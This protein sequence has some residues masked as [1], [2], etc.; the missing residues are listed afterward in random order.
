M[1]DEHKTI[2]QQIRKLSDQI[3]QLS[4]RVALLEKTA[5]T[6]AT[7]SQQRI[8]VTQPSSEA[9]TVEDSSLLLDS[10][11]L[12][13][14]VSILCFLLVAALGLRALTDS[15]ILNP[16]I[17]SILG[18][19]YAAS[20]II[21]S[22]IFYRGSSPLAP[23]FSI[24]GALLMF[25][26]MVE[27]HNH[28]ATLPEEIA[29]TMLATTGIGMAIISYR[30]KVALPII[31][32]TLGMCFSAVAIGYPT[33]HFPYLGL[34][35]WASNI[36]GFFATRLKRCSWL[37]WLL[38]LTTHLMLQIWG[39]KLSGFMTYGQGKTEQLSPGLFI[40]V[41]TLIGFTFMMIALF[42][43]IRSGDDKVSKFD[44]SLPALNASWCYVA[45]I[46]ALKNPTAFGAPAA[47]AAFIHFA[48]AYWLS[49]RQTSNA[50]G[51]NTFTAGGVILACLSLPAVLGDLFLSLPA[52]SLLAIATCYFAHRWSSGGMRIT[53][54][55]LQAYISVIFVIEFIRSIGQQHKSP[56]IFFVVLFCS[57][58]ALLHYHYARQTKPPEHSRIFSQYDRKDLSALL[59]LFAGLINSYFTCMLIAFYC[60]QYYY[61]EE[62]TIALTGTQSIVI[63]LAAIFI[64]V[65]S[66]FN[67][68]PELRN[69]S[70]L[71]LAIGGCKV[72]II[73]MLN[74]SGAWLVCSIFTFGVAAALASLIL[75]RW[76]TTSN[77]DTR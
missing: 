65:R 21:V 26:V 19:V 28:F 53:S 55:L 56:E 32:G 66:F 75:A 17:G 10:S 43:I 2:K 67:D 12:L 44:F 68:N 71:I 38:L 8:P 62:M 23:I 58:L 41:V 54:Y 57:I 64:M 22:H 77:P 9:K 33:P 29:Y 34:M 48:L 27:T 61:Q 36:L 49:R 69:V 14:N 1:E 35:L 60:L 25:S 7:V 30:H 5:G 76:K 37:R 3:N 74:I 31:V 51:T 50:Q 46:Y 72:F 40:P 6:E 13:K 59:P 20:L 63:N 11:S 42:G 16:Q 39:L 15:S 18:T 52:L 4:Q 45:G 47:A 70:I 73:D 24:T